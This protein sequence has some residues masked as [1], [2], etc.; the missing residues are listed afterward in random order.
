MGAQHVLDNPSRQVLLLFTLRKKIKFR[1]LEQSS[2][3]LGDIWLQ[4]GG[5]GI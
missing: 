5:S 4:R 2:S 3:L 1:G